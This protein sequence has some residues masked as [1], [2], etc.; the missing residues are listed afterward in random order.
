MGA[1]IRWSAKS[2]AIYRSGTVE[3]DFVWRL[4]IEARLG[5]VVEQVLNCSY[6]MKIETSDGCSFGTGLSDQAVG[7][8]VCAALMGAA[9]IS[10]IHFDT[11]ISSEPTAIRE[12]RAVVKCRTSPMTSVEFLQALPDCLV[13]VI[14]VP[15]LVWSYS[16]AFSLWSRSGHRMLL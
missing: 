3:E 15:I 6:L 4:E 8:L 5:A 10:D 12:L 14:S 9:R 7:L 2:V 16:N 1:F 13:N 11:G